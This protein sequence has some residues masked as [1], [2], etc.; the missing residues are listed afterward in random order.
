M[1]GRGPI[2]WG[3]PEYTVGRSAEHDLSVRACTGLAGRASL[4]SPAA[5]KII[6]PLAGPA[7]NYTTTPKLY[8]HWV[9]T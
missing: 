9:Y 5:P 3:Q 7:K 1:T 2:F 8:D 6:R 4:D